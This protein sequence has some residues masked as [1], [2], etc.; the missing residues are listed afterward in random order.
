MS[1]CFVTRVAGFVGSN[2]AVRLLSEGF[3]VIGVDCFSNYYS[4]TQKKNNLKQLLKSKS[5]TFFEFNLVKQVQFY[6]KRKL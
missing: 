6:T 5:F 1:L 3:N 4:I 2:V